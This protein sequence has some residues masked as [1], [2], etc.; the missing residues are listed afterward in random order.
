MQMTGLHVQL[1]LFPN[2]CAREHVRLLSVS[3]SLTG[4]CPADLS[5]IYS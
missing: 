1:G 5:G 2:I 3:L 4:V